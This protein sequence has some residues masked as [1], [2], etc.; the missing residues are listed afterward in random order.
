[1]IEL[2]NDEIAYSE[3][4]DQTEFSLLQSWQWGEIKKPQWKPIRILINNLPL[5]ILI[6][7]LP[8]N[9]KF[10]YIPRAL[11]DSAFTHEHI[12][13]IKHFCNNELKLSHL[14]IEP[15]V[16]GNAAK[17]AIFVTLKFENTGKTIQPN[18]TIIM[19]LSKTEDELWMS[20]RASF[21][22]NIKKAQK[23]GCNVVQFS[24]GQEALHRFLK[25]ND[26]VQ[27]RNSFVKHSH[28]YFAKIWNLLSER[29]MCK[30]FI[31]TKDERDI[32]SYFL[33]Y[34]NQQAFE[35]YGGVTNEGK[36]LRA[37]H[38]LKWTTIKDAKDSG[39]RLYDQWGVARW[40]GEDFDKNDELYYVSEFK[41]GFGG[42]YVQYMNQQT[43]IFKKL[44]YKIFNLIE[45]INRTKLKLTKLLT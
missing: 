24:E 36:P 10:G 45:G 30:I 27:T 14:I 43:I 39:K 32:A 20:L 38:L 7:T 9:I 40:L 13:E 28:E 2:V 22:R 41:A 33:A 18:Q 17:E 15:N 1:M 37:G 29:Q 6:R 16:R 23:N 3:F 5:T 31:V 42:Q 35:L 34:T 21:R 11:N 8:F 25:V 12:A 26:T 44:K 4:F 19:D